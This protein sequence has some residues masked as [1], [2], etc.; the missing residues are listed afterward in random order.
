MERAIG[1]NVRCRAMPHRSTGWRHGAILLIAML[2][3]TCIVLSVSEASAQCAAR[4]AL[5][6]HLT[7]NKTRFASMPPIP[8]RSAAAVPVWKTITVGKY[9]NSFALINALDAASCSIGDSAGEI[10]A[11]NEFNVLLLALFLMGDHSRNF[12]VNGL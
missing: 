2:C 8:I 5:R 6:N 4:D 1:R 7:V 11:R 12:R 3:A 9:A 10:L